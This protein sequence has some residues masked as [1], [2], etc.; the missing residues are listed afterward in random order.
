[1]PS[2]CELLGVLFVS[3]FA[4]LPR[5]TTCLPITRTHNVYCALPMIRA[6]WTSEPT[7]ASMGV[8]SGSLGVSKDDSSVRLRGS[9]HHLIFAVRLKLSSACLRGTV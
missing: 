6:A 5:A 1:M 8:R 9:M 2:L 4:R 7:L 3:S